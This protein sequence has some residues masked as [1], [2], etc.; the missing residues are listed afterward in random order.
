MSRCFFKK[1][2]DVAQNCMSA[3][4]DDQWKVN[5]LRLLSDGIIVDGG[6]K[7]NFTFKTE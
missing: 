6:K 3:I 4:S 2:D 7:S 1:A 5:K